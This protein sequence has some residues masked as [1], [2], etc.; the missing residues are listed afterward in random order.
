MKTISVIVPC[1]NEEST[2]L[3]FF[4]EAERVRRELFTPLDVDFEYLFVDDG[5]TDKTLELIKGLREKN[6]RVRFISFSRNFGK[7]AAMLAGMENATGDFVTMLDADLQDPPAMLRT[8]YDGIVDEG[9]DQVAARRV[10]RKGEPILKT[11]GA[12]AFYKLIDK[13][14]DVEMVSGAR[15]FRLMKRKVVEAILALPEKCRYS[16]GIFSFVGFRTKWIPYENSKRV[17][18]VSKFPLGKLIRYAFEGITAFSTAPLYLSAVTG[19]LLL[20]GGIVTLILA[21]IFSNSVLTG[22]TIGLL[23]GGSILLGLGILGQYLSQIFIEIKARP[24][25]IVR[26]TE[27]DH[28][29]ELKKD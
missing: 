9:Y 16:K 27:T 14:S 21:I 24:V 13:L 22:C 1:Y 12:N 25:Y 7:E 18:G 17:A 19:G 15:D 20:T 29:I 28:S 6:D 26:E 3:T 4:G 2:V 11:I 5:S 10:T 8:M 23:I